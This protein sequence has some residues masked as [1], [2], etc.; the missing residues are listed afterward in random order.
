[1]RRSHGWLGTAA[2]IGTLA[3]P[4][5]ARADGGLVAEWP[6][7]EGAGAKAADTSGNGNAGALVG[8]AQWVPG[9]GN[10]TALTFDGGGGR[11]QVP[12]SATL[13]ATAV[14][15]SA[16]VR[17]SGSP[18]AFKYLVAKGA[19][20]CLAASFGLYTGP[21]GG[22]M[23]YVAN[24]GYSFARS[25]DAGG[26]L[27]DGRWH[28]VAGTYDGSTVRMYLDGEQVGSGAPFSA[29]I[30]YGLATTD[31][32]S[33]GSYRGCS[34]LDFDGSIDDPKI[35][36][37]ALSPDE[38][39]AQSQ[40]AF[41]GFFSPINKAPTLNSAK[42]GSAIPVKFSLTGN[43]GL[44]IMAAGSPSSRKVTCATGVPVDAIEETV[45]AGNSSLQYDASGDQYSYVWKTD[46]SWG[47][48]CR[49]LDVRLDDGSSHTA[50]F[51]F[52]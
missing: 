5:L 9:H 7:D 47:G 33:I 52:K 26:G 10:G 49:E 50:V 15:V 35:W 42:G 32:V 23:F 6:F 2:L 18:G 30:G 24:D 27:W 12:R 3:V 1:M 11:V 4:S 16:W 8:G 44:G 40:Y 41:R 38:V 21:N 28:H 36:S 39:L 48:T 17:R 22:L 51:Q 43:F 34:G 45:S 19:T 25:A 31:D 29:P 46:K 37:R 13:E 14:S 20:G